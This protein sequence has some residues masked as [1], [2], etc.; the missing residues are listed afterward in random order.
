MIASSSAAS[1]R[2][3][4]DWW[5]VVVL[6]GSWWTDWCESVVLSGAWSGGR[7]K[8]VEDEEEERR[9]GVE[10]GP[11]MLAVSSDEEIRLV[12]TATGGCGERGANL[13]RKPGFSG[14]RRN[15]QRYFGRAVMGR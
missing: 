12:A 15:K 5:E 3:R 1:R 2:E 7:L 11:D 14:R 10:E 4:A 6:R 8:D 13:R 9:P